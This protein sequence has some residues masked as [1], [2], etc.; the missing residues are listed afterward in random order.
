MTGDVFCFSLSFFGF[1]KRNLKTQWVSSVLGV[2]LGA[3]RADLGAL[4]V[5]LGALGV[6]LGALGVDLGALAF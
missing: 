1:L 6:D 3:Q 5:D 2:D 4:R